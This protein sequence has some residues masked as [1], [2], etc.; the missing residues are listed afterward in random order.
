MNLYSK[1]IILVLV[2]CCIATSVL[3]FA[4]SYSQPKVAS[5]QEYTL[6]EPIPCIDENGKACGLKDKADLSDY[7]GYLFR[8]MIALAVFFAVVVIS[9][10]GF[11]YMT[12]EAITG[13]SDARNRIQNAVLGLLLALCSYLI[14]KTIDPRLIEINTTIPPLTY[15]KV[16]FSKQLTQQLV[17]QRAA[18]LSVIRDKEKQIEINN[19]RIAEIEEII[20]NN[21]YGLT[22]EE[23]IKLENEL[24]SLKERNL[25]ISADVIDQRTGSLKDINYQNAIRVLEQGALKTDWSNLSTTNQFDDDAAREAEIYM[26]SIKSSYDKAIM[27]Y[28]NVDP[29]KAETLRD[30]YA[31]ISS[32]Y[33]IEKKAIAL[34]K[35]SQSKEVYSD[36]LAVEKKE[37]FDDLRAE[38]AKISPTLENSPEIKKKYADDLSE[39]ALRVQTQAVKK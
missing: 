39:I 22:A 28:E 12:T 1:K 17:S 15:T 14:L 26:R 20:K 2:L 38:S 9:W 10:A 37:F 3:S 35:Y 13:K 5:A 36:Q 16:D 11:E 8:L 30:E 18:E 29:V 23:Q 21:F 33:E 34:I 25:T 6:L 32:K 27:S 24:D 19:Q 4:F 31:Y 7:L